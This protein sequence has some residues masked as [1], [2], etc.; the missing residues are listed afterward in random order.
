MLP[1]AHV[2]CWGLLPHRGA[3]VG[4]FGLLRPLCSR[5]E[6]FLGWQGTARG[7]WEETP[8]LDFAGG[9]REVSHLLQ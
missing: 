8:D 6:C 2:H 3:C 5:G 1:G 7:L 9:W 4:G